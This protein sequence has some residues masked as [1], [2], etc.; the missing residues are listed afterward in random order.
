[1]ISF[2]EKCSEVVSVQAWVTVPGVEHVPGPTHCP[3]PAPHVEV[4]TKD[5]GC[6]EHIPPISVLSDPQSS[7]PTS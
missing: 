4:E 6:P 7:L 1:M 3:R 5:Q 2:L